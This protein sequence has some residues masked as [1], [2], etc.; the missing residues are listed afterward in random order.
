MNLNEFYQTKLEFSHVVQMVRNHIAKE[1]FIR[2]VIL[3]VSNSHER[4]EEA[5]PK[6]FTDLKS[7]AKYG[8]KLHS[9][10]SKQFLHLPNYIVS[11]TNHCALLGTSIVT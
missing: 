4:L 9:H 10:A 8:D 1:N 2:K 7:N 6:Y 11:H 5:M 3:S